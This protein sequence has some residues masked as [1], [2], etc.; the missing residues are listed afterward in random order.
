MTGDGVNDALA[1]KDADLGIAMGN[2]AQATKSAAKAV[3]IDSKF[4][5]LPQVL[6][7]GRRVLGNMER[8][9]TLFL[10]KTTYAALLALVVGV[11]GVRYPYLPRHL[12]LI[13]S[14]TIG[15]PAFFLALAPSNRRYR[16]GFLRRVGQLALPAGLLCGA[17]SI[18]A[19]LWIGRTEA[20]TSVATIVLAIGALGLLAI[21]SRP[22]HS[23]RGG[24]V[25][26]MIA[27]VITAIAVPVVRNFFALEILSFAQWLVVVICSL[28]SLSG[29]V[30]IGT[31]WERRH[32]PD[33]GSGLRLKHVRIR[34]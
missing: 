10:S 8:V 23:W 13:S 12:T 5:T 21:L 25:I 19:Y 15:I 18:A 3:L 4:S 34:R 29:L 22:L 16:P 31:R 14:T 20:A 7:E 9:S 30:I 6:R 28:I 24:L 1:L 33:H 26:A 11:L 27:L 17:T 2:A 32:W